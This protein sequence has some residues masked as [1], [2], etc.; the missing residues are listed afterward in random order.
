MLRLR[1]SC[2]RQQQ[3]KL[4]S[5][6]VFNSE[7][8]TLMVTANHFVLRKFILC[9]PFDCTQCARRVWTCTCMANARN[10]EVQQKREEK[11]NWHC[12]PGCD[13]KI[14]ICCAVDSFS[15]PFLLFRVLFYAYP[16]HTRAPRHTT[17][18]FLSFVLFIHSFIRSV[19]RSGSNIDSSIVIAGSRPLFHQM[20][21][22]CLHSCFI[23]LLLFIYFH[24]FLSVF[25]VRY[26]LI[27]MLSM[28]YVYYFLSAVYIIRKII[29]IKN[30]KY[31]IYLTRTSSVA[32][33][34]R[35]HFN[36]VS[37]L[38]FFLFMCL[39]QSSVCVLCT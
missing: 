37:F 17:F 30:N 14:V 15:T 34:S 28:L 19:G 2:V 20:H 36:C 33:E 16:A 11:E 24:I 4:I 38:L 35:I 1:G 26:V 9:F 8:A 18:V 25:V 29:M 31:S 6:D 12:S 7:K 21:T 10:S 22:R 32:I 13:I 23:L 5:P 39:V 27:F 3:H